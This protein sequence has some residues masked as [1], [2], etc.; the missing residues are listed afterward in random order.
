MAAYS[1]YV[2][3]YYGDAIAELNRFLKIYPS[4]KNISYAHYLLGINYYEQIVDEKKDLKSIM[5]S[6]KRFEYVVNT[7]P[8]T[9]YALDA[10]FKINLINDIFASKEMYIGDIILKKKWI[11]AINRFRQY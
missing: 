6:K 10:K 4:N 2:Q 7:F 9:D 3:D 1:Y 8:D 5:M 11:P